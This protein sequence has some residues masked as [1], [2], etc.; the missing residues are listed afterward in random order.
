[1]MKL[2]STLT[3]LSLAATLSFAGIAAHAADT[4][5][6]DKKFLADSG[7]GSLAE[8]EM[9]KLALANS[10]NKDVR[11]FAQKMIHDHTMLISSMKPYAAKMDVPP[12]TKD[13][14]PADAKDE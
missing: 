8:V 7:E 12:P 3:A 9:A 6:D 2:A 5:S 14:L 13:G 10:T 4:S 1:M 11:T